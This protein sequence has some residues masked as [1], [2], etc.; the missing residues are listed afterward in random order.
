M[1]E[2][3]LGEALLNLSIRVCIL[4]SSP[5]PHLDKTPY[6]SNNYVSTVAPEPHHDTVQPEEFLAGLT[7]P[8]SSCSL[9]G[10]TCSSP[11]DFCKHKPGQ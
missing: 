7:G 10:F 5:L 3:F 6:I 9:I 2:C 8:W 4:S 1:G 11:V